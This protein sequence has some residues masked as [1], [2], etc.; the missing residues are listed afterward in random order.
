MIY[1]K[2]YIL[3]AIGAVILLAMVDL[4]MWHVSEKGPNSGLTHVTVSQWGQEKYLIYLPVYIAQEEGFFKDHGL[5]VSIT[6]SGNDDQV[7]ATV[8]RGDAQFGVGDPIF[9][10]ISRQRGFDGIVVAS[11]VDRVAGGANFFL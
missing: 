2:K 6:F 3:I 5:D 8:A 7:F 9:T 1:W 10:A 4:L 11:I